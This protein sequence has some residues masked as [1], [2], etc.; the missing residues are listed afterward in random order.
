MLLSS[1]SY[2]NDLSDLEK[3]LVAIDKPKPGIE[4]FDTKIIDHKSYSGWVCTDKE[5]LEETH[6]RFVSELKA[7]RSQYKRCNFSSY[8]TYIFDKKDLEN[9]LIDIIKTRSYTEL[10][11][12]NYV[13]RDKDYPGMFT[14]SFICKGCEDS[15]EAIKKNISY[16]VMFGTLLGAVRDEDFI[17]Y[18]NDIDLIVLDANIEKVKLCLDDFSKINLHPIRVQSDLISLFRNGDYI[19][20]NFFKTNYHKNVICSDSYIF[21]YDFFISTSKVTIRGNEFSSPIRPKELLLQIYG[22]DWRT[23]KRNA[24]AKYNTFSGRIKNLLKKILSER[25]RQFIRVIFPRR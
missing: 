17:E 25:T 2:A 10:S 21:P 23:P 9:G 20:I 22:K 19:D 6:K 13:I 4:R 15:Q 12:Y 16:F 24:T 5:L 7:Q 1:F 14:L 11:P 18:D 3:Q 8:V